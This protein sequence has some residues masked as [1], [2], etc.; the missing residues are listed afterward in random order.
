MGWSPTN[1]GPPMNPIHNLRAAL[2]DRA[3][4]A[5]VAAAWGAIMLGPARAAEVKVKA[6][7][8]VRQ[9][10]YHSPQSPGYTCWVGTWAMPDGRVMVC[11]TQATGPVEG[12]LA[13]G[14]IGGKGRMAEPEDIVA[15]VEAT[16]AERRD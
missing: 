7:D 13:S 16:L 5:F 8:H 9:T 3:L 6:V 10:I 14:K 11:F 15:Q 4:R 12:R 2:E 1:P